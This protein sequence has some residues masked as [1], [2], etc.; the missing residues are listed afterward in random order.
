MDTL[1][2]E[3][4]R[5]MF[6]IRRFEETMLE[7]FAKGLL[8]GTVHTC[9]GQE[10]CSVGVVNALE[11]G[12]DIVF[13]SHRGHGHYLALTD[14]VEGLTAELMGRATGVCGGVGGTQHLHRDNFYSNGVQGG[15]VPV[16]T[17][18]ALA[19]REK[20]TS[21]I[22]TVFIGDGTFGQG[23]VYESFNIASK[24]SLPILYVIED[25]Q[26]AQTTHVHMVHAGELK[27]RL[28]PFGIVGGALVAEDI[29]AVYSEAKRW[30]H[31]V[32]SEQHPAFLYLETYRFSPHSKG[33]DFRPKQEI[34]HYRQKDPLKKLAKTLDVDGRL[35]IE[36]SVENRLQEAIKTAMEMP[37]QQF[38]EY[39]HRL[40]EKGV[41]SQ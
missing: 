21:A 19:E 16:A 34:D 26:Y 20:G 9:I 18:M 33:D 30:V 14:D 7:L 15:I 13:S 3:F 40:V 37:T 36:E 22:V 29:L 35:K 28:R 4:Y 6:T 25:N 41:Y 17:G 23:V 8:N 12:L 1:N 32:R 31:L 11:K 10:A 39:R 27:E 38:K 5:Q 24:W 2:A